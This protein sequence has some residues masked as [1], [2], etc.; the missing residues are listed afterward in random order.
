MALNVRFQYPTGSSLGVSIERLSDGLLYDFADGTFKGSPG[1]LIQAVAEDVAP[2][3]GRYK[4][5]LTPTPEAQFSD[6]D[7]VVTVHDAANAGQVVAELGA[8]MKGGSDGTYFPPA[9]PAPGT[10][11]ATVV[12]S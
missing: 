8:T 7:Y 10:Y 4:A 11:H 6:G 9:A 5:T 3:L 1:T 2:F 12:L